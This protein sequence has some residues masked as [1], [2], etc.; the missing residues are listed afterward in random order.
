MFPEL[1]LAQ[2]LDCG[3]EDILSEIVGRFTVP[4][5][6]CRYHQY[7]ATVRID[8]LLFGRAISFELPT[9]VVRQVTYTELA[10][11]GDTSGKSST[12]SITSACLMRRL[13]SASSA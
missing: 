9:T 4:G 8:Q 13:G 2:R 10:V 7:T 5:A 12:R 1:S 3:H 11:R 6:C